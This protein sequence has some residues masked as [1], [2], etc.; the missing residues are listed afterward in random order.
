M[1]FIES[2]I[3]GLAGYLLIF[4]IRFFYLKIRKIEGMGLGDAKLFFLIGY[5]VV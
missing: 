5:A 1:G 3:G 2:I 4:L